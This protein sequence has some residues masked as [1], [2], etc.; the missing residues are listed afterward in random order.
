MYI[1]KHV[2]HAKTCNSS[3]DRILQIQSSGKFS[4][5]DRQMHSTI[6]MYTMCGVSYNSRIYRKIKTAKFLVPLNIFYTGPI[7]CHMVTIPMSF[8]EMCAL[9][10]WYIKINGMA[11]YIQVN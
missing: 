5:Y 11:L 6:L 8:I 3:M 9:K 7:C 4:A 2:K 1:R 10:P